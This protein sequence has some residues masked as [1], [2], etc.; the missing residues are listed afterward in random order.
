MQSRVRPV[1][2]VDR[3]QE[4]R[5]I[6]EGPLGN[7][8]VSRDTFVDRVQDCAGCRQFTK[9]QLRR[10]FSE[11]DVHARGIITWDDFTTFV[12]HQ[13]S[14]LHREDLRAI[15]FVPSAM[16]Q[17][18]SSQD[19]KGRLRRVVTTAT[20]IITG[21][22][23]GLLKQWSPHGD[24]H[25]ITVCNAR[26][27]SGVEQ[28][29]SLA[30]LSGFNCPVRDMIIDSRGTA[31]YVCAADRSINAYDVE[32][33]DLQRKYVARELYNEL[34]KST[35]PRFFNR[36]NAP[37]DTV[38]LMGI[39][40]SPCAVD[41]G[42]TTNVGEH[43]VV[44]LMNGTVLS[45]SLRN[46]TMTELNPLWVARP[47]N[48]A[49]EKLR[50]TPLLGLVS[51][52]WDRD[53]IITNPLNGQVQT[54]LVGHARAC[55]D[56]CFN[57][58]MRLLTTVAM[59]R[60]A[61]VWNPSVDTPI[62]RM[63][64]AEVL[65]AITLN[66]AD[67]QVVTLDNRNV[68]Y[69]W[70]SGGSFVL[71]TLT[72]TDRTAL[73]SCLQY[74]RATQSVVGGAHRPIVWRM[75]RSIANFT[76]TYR[77]HLE[78]VISVDMVSEFQA[79]I[80]VDPHTVM[81]WDVMDGRREMV[82]TPFR[83]EE[84]IM[85]SSCTTR[86]LAIVS[87]KG[88]ILIFNHRNAQLLSSHPPTLELKHVPLKALQIS[89]R[90]GFNLDHRVVAV[91][92]QKEL[93]LSHEAIDGEG[94]HQHL[95]CRANCKFTTAIFVPATKSYAV[96]TVV[97]A[98]TTAGLLVFNVA[99]GSQLFTAS[100]PDDAIPGALSM[101][102]SD[103]WSDLTNA[104]RV[105]EAMVYLKRQDLIA[106]V[107]GGHHIFFWNFTGASMAQLHFVLDTNMTVDEMLVCLATDEENTMI[108]CADDVGVV[109]IRD[110][111]NMERFRF[112][113]AYDTTSLPLIR[114]FRAHRVAVSTIC[115]V[116]KRKLIATAAMD[117]RVRLFS[118]AG[119]FVGFFG[120][121]KVWNVASLASST[122]TMD[123]TDERD[124]PA[125][126]DDVRK[127]DQVLATIGVLMTEARSSGTPI[128]RAAV[129][130]RMSRQEPP[131]NPCR[132]QR[133]PSQRGKRTVEL[134]PIMT[135]V[136]RSSESRGALSPNVG[137]TQ[138]ERCRSVLGR[139]PI[140]A[141][142]PILKFR[143]D[144]QT[145]VQLSTFDPLSPLASRSEPFQRETLPLELLGPI[146]ATPVRDKLNPI[147]KRFQEPA[148]RA[149]TPEERPNTRLT[150]LYAQFGG[151]SPVAEAL[152]QVEHVNSPSSSD[153]D[154]SEEFDSSAT[155][156]PRTVA[157]TAEAIQAAR[158]DN[159]LGWTMRTA[160][161]MRT[162]DVPH[163]AK[164]ASAVLQRYLYNPPLPKA[165]PAPK[166]LPPAPSTASR[167]T[168]TP[169]AKK[170]RSAP[171]GAT[172]PTNVRRP[173]NL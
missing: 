50:I 64:H 130:R 10:W 107:I 151:A 85:C 95:P 37:V 43:L 40:D 88:R 82:W 120:Q 117:G 22:N 62:A 32:T 112:G 100:H 160:T 159:P 6:F 51:V 73:I 78:T 23:D 45:Y 38:V 76:T 42:H 8:C 122:A 90:D 48:G 24:V 46:L 1:L 34:G 155:N 167:A 105:V 116:E 63:P 121:P 128:P 134:S 28:S 17:P 19:H 58:R 66:E 131:P 97:V 20:G 118:L 72:S 57:Q 104:S 169:L 158:R 67:N 89:W 93:Q 153:G 59:E 2:A 44:A 77:G 61:L 126:N 106:T 111:S 16:V 18:R 168:R 56:F 123:D 74:D 12:I 135:I 148:E 87:Q 119:Q 139:R 129:V 83:D 114:A 140:D 171:F 113:V 127:A 164:D 54:R 11:M 132:Q 80:T 31:L 101:S 94:R 27:S 125:N 142:T 172:A 133:A 81:T 149:D 96:P 141:A 33:M 3:I 55:V 150:S 86:R 35:V 5:R 29:Y 144:Q 124:V 143:G 47:H 15:E 145:P 163:E 26:V 166:P 152:A 91:M 70:E 69:V 68:A 84:T 162:T 4:L 137:A 13:A 165:K 71:Q 7:A 108:F 14:G 173:G 157:P 53:V 154:D 170:K 52:G 36:A 156:G 99:T 41:V 75:R 49:V 161:L 98:T 109:Y 136:K 102:T 103:M 147:L 30:S 60:D 21:G 9:V 146:T 110:I 65:V 25:L 79:L 138:S 39:N 115:F 92:T